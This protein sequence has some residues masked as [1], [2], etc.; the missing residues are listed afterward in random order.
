MQ[1]VDEDWKT[2]SFCQILLILHLYFGKGGYHITIVLY[3]A[4][5]SLLRD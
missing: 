4:F 1:A 3:L 5:L 2:S